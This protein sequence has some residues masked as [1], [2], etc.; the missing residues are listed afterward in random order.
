MNIIGGRYINKS[1]N[2]R[3]RYVEKGIN[4]EEGLV[5]FLNIQSF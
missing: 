5:T 1:F 2:Q 3:Y 4:D